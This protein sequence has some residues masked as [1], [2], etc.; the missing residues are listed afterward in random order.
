MA[1]VQ[2][3]TTSFKAELYQGV[4]DLLT[5]DIYIALYNG[6]ANL[7]APPLSTPLPTKSLVQGTRPVANNFWAQ[8]LIHRAPL[9]M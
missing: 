3:Q 4:H 5:D 2:T 8:Q 1:I 9:P 6:N 7:D